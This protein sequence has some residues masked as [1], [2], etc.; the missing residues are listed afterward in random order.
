MPFQGKRRVV[1]KIGREFLKFTIFLYMICIL[2]CIVQ[3]DGT[4]AVPV[5]A[6]ICTAHVFDGGGCTAHVFDD[7][8]C[9]DIVF[10]TIDCN[11]TA[12]LQKPCTAN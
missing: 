12:N 11:V 9:T 5:F 1:E 6:H 4:N 10:A 7:G 3:D 2:I 8:G